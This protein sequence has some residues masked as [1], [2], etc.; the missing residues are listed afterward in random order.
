MM[1]ATAN[2]AASITAALAT[3]A[4]AVIAIFQWREMRKQ[5]EQE[6]GRWKQEDAR[7]KQDKR[8]ADQFDR[9]KWMESRFNSPAMLAARSA[10]GRKL[11]ASAASLS[12]MLGSP[13]EQA[14]IPIYF[15]AQIAQMW[16]KDLLALDDIAVAYGNFINLLW[17][18]FGEF[19][20]N[21]HLQ[22]KFKILEDL[23]NHLSK[24]DVEFQMKPDQSG[25]SAAALDFVGE[26]FWKRE[27]SL[28]NDQG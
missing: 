19:L 16:K 15:F 7:A 4:L 21:D 26:N 18:K 22:G 12:A 1:A 17:F 11:T 8:R 9:L 13:N 23:K 14:W 6:Y 20:I 3:A 24:I 28:V 27:A 25:F 10:L 5:R 2:L